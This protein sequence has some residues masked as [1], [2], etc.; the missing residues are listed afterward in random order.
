MLTISIVTYNNAGIISESLTSILAHLPKNIPAELIIVDNCSQDNTPRI[1]ASY[2]EKH[3]NVS[4]ILNE[5][6]TGYGAGHNLAVK[7]L[8]SQYHVICNP[9]ILLHD[10]ILTPL[11]SFLDRNQDIGILCPRFQFRDGSLQP[12]NRRYPTVLDLF[13]RRF[14][15]RPFRPL[16]QKRLDYYEM[17]DIG[18]EHICDVPFISGAFMFCRTEVLKQNGGFDEGYFLYFEDVDLCRRVQKRHRTVYFPYVSVTHFWERAAH[19]RWIYTYHFIKSA[20]RYFNHWG[21]RLF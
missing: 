19:K 8:E 16:F 9:D 11:T 21:Y 10:D 14:L 7:N 13:L 20:F 4:V 15:P 12:L 1:L 6:N 17:L 2:A 3:G 18:Y 5:P